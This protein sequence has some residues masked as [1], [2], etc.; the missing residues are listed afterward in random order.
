M[1]LQFISNS[2]GETTGVFIPIDEWND[3]KS[4]YKGIEGEELDIPDWHKAI[5]NERYQQYL[6]DP[7]QVIDFDAAMDDIEKDM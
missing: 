2:E 6:N 5:V 1:S 3:L 4:K 7:T